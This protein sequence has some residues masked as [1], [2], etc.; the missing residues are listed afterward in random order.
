MSVRSRSRRSW[1]REDTPNKRRMRVWIFV[2]AVHVI[3]KDLNLDLGEAEAAHGITRFVRRTSETPGQSDRR[4]PVMIAS[5]IT[6]CLIPTAKWN[7]V[8]SSAPTIGLDWVQIPSSDQSCKPAAKMAVVSYVEPKSDLIRKSRSD[9]EIQIR[10]G[11]PDR[12]WPA[13]PNLVWQSDQLPIRPVK[14]LRGTKT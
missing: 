6:N 8:A 7:S 13:R 14:C 2:A 10:L 4:G 5:L 1:W 3:C 11:N 9:W 12:I